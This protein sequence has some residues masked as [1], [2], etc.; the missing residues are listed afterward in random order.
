MEEDNNSVV[1]EMEI[2]DEE[3][4][5]IFPTPLAILDGKY[6]LFQKLGEGSTASVYLGHS[7]CD[8]THTLYSFKIVNPDKNDKTLFER[9]VEML[10]QIDHE[11]VMKVYHSGMGKL[12]KAN[13]EINE[14]LNCYICKHSCKYYK[15]EDIYLRA[16]VELQRKE[17]DR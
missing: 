9:E 11:N 3:E 17:M 12:Q 10:G 6:H 7:P 16:M 13:G 5:N 8:K 2:D 1:T 15:K 14:R 4:D